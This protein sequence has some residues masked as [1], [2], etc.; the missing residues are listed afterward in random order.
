GLEGLALRV[1]RTLDVA[2]HLDAR[3]RHDARFETCGAAVDLASVCLR[4]LPRWARA[5]DPAGRAAQG[6]RARL[7]D[8]QRRLQQEVEREGRAW[9]PAI[10]LQDTVWL[11][12]GIFNDRTTE[13]DVDATLE[14][15][16]RAAVRL[17]LDEKF[18]RLS[19]RR[20][21]AAAGGRRSRSSRG[22]S[23]G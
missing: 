14:I 3:V 12:F 10:W 2:R 18:S 13:R 6:A 4:Y 5:L 7:N 23:R 8:A 19:G 1:Q 11:R 20:A 16:A 22:R 17:G 21:S 9:F 15:V